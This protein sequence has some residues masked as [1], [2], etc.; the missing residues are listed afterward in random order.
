MR[1]RFKPSKGASLSEYAILASLVAV[2][3]I[4][5]VAGTGTEVRHLF[6]TAASTLE[7]GDGQVK[8]NTEISPGPQPVPSAPQD[9]EDDNRCPQNTS[10]GAFCPDGT[11]YAGQNPA[12][13]R[14]FVP[15]CDAG[16]LWE[17]TCTG[18]RSMLAWGD[19][20]P[21]GATYTGAN[22]AL[23]GRANTELLASLDA[24]GILGGHQAHAA[25]SYCAGLNTHER[26]DWY[27]PSIDEAMRLR[28]VYGTIR[29]FQH[30][31]TY[32]T[33]TQVA[34]NPQNT[35]WAVGAAGAQ[36]RAKGQTGPVRCLRTEP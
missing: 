12:G 15:P 31:A 3:A 20:S 35:A 9:P 6:A 8:D 36:E 5:G 26:A 24:N 17:T 21:S 19:G 13:G 29:H 14:M 32:W 23:N 4:A 22:N 25:A 16:M 1:Q 11:I 27:L 30:T 2:V 28:D 18:S 7:E 33:S 10:I 34:S